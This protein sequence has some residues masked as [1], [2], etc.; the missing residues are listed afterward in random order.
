MAVDVASATQA[1]IQAQLVPVVQYTNSATVA[2]GFV[3]SQTPAAGTVVPV[4]SPVTLVVSKGLANTLTNV[5]VPNLVGLTWKAATD[6]LQ[7][8]FLTL[9]KYKFAVSSSAQGSVTAQSV[10][11]GSSV[12]VGT[13]VQLTLSA[14]PAKVPATVSVPVAS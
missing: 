13:L 1:V 12:P 4:N 7:A 14:G 3:V 11:A 2:A 10:L 8:A 9:D 6:A 5:T